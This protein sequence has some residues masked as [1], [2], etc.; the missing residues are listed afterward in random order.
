MRKMLN[1]FEV[2]T[3][4]FYIMRCSFVGITINNLI[5]VAKQDGYISIILGFIIGFIPLLLY[6][7]LM[8][9]KKQYNINDLIELCFGKTIGR[10]INLALCC[11]LL[12]LSTVIFWNLTNL[13]TSQ[14]LSRTPAM[15]IGIMFIVPTIYL[16]SKGIGI[17]GKCSVIFFYFSLIL[18]ILPILGLQFQVHLDNIM[19]IFEHGIMP[20]LDGSYQYIANSV[21]VLFLLL[22]IP[23]EM[24]QDDHKFNKRIITM[25][26]VTSV[27]L[28]SILFLTITVFGAR[29]ATLYQYPEFHLLK[30]VSIIGFIQRIES[31]LSIQ[32]IFDIFMTNILTLYFVCHYL[33]KTF[34]LQQKWKRNTLITCLSI[35]VLISSNYVFTNNTIGTLFFKNTFPTVLYGVLLS[36]PLL[37]AIIS[38]FK[39]N[40]SF[41]A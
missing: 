27:I 36:L 40:K 6:L 16:L 30:R 17:I 20:I 31:T 29:L 1:S 21:L 18:V 4:V 32:W 15:A 10:F 13:I 22:S 35:L 33:T 25:Y 9:Y 26:C 8:N 14:Y 28:F 12:Y 19:P 38:K 2:S 11:F 41:Q 34:R 3:F 23:K 39:K 7:Y 5:L 37:V 24:I